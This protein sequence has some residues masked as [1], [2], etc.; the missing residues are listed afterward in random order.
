MSEASLF[1]RFYLPILVLS[2]AANLLLVFWIT[3]KDVL[4]RSFS[5]PIKWEVASQSIQQKLI[6]L[7][8]LFAFRQA[9]ITI[10]LQNYFRQLNYG[11]LAL[12]IGV[13]SVAVYTGLWLSLRYFEWVNNPI[14]GLLGDIVQWQPISVSLAILA[15]GWVVAKSPR[16]SPRYWQFVYITIAGFTLYRLI[17]QPFTPQF[18][19]DHGSL[20][21]FIQSGVPYPSWII[22]NSLLGWLFAGIWQFPSFNQLLPPHLQSVSGFVAC[23]S[24]ISIALSTII[25]LKVWP[26]RLWIIFPI[27]SPFWILFGLGYSEYYPFLVGPLIAAAALIFTKPLKEHSP[28]AIGTLATSIALLYNAFIPIAI[29]LLVWYAIVHPREIVKTVGICLAE[30]LT[31][32]TVCWPGSIQDYFG[33]LYANMN[34]GE[35]N[36]FFPRYQGKSAGPNSIFFSNQYAVSVEHLQDVFYFCFWGGVFIFLA[37]IV[38]GLIGAIWQTI[39]GKKL[40]GWPNT[41]LGLALSI[42]FFLAYYI[43]FMI[44]KLGIPQDVDLFF[45]VYVLSAFFAGYLWDWLLRD[46]SYRLSANFFLTAMVLGESLALL[47][48][49]VEVGIPAF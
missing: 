41:N 25:L 49:L 28:I 1:S 44:P 36:T 26:N 7:S 6:V 16:W 15:G 24:I 3:R 21:N 35:A 8:Q 40:R 39:K 27:L 47:A 29:L 38:I 12:G 42:I 23:A 31:I 10:E 20:E 2:L 45:F 19:G 30:T 18:Y 22:G 13:Y 32:L 37:L 46:K 5:S 4:Q 33:K 14:P 34:W 11:V 43:I 17:Q 9:S 48:F